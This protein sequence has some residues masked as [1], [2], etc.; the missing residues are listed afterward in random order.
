MSTTLN[1]MSDSL[2]ARVNL[3]AY[4]RPFSGVGIEFDPLGI[5]PGRTGITLHETGF[6]PANAG[7]NFPGVFSP[8]RKSVV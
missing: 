8:D 4:D 6:H 5:Q 1:S 3:G 7:W 2:A